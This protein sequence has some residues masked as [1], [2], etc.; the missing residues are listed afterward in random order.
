MARTPIQDPIKALWKAWLARKSPAFRVAAK[1]LALMTIYYLV[2]LSPFFDHNTIKEWL[3]ANARLASFV[4]NLMGEQSHVIENLVAPEHTFG[5]TVGKACAALNLVWFYCAAV[6]AFPSKWRR[7]IP[8]LLVGVPIILAL[9]LI[10]IM[11][12]YLI[13]V[14][15]PRAFDWVHEELW[16]IVLV[17]AILFLTLAWIGWAQN[18]DGE[19]TD[20]A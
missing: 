1:F 14:H 4:L 11:S 13:G 15:F 9:N 12:L 3:D 17:V 5:V 8:G 2:I 19:N 16:A 6:L 7:K 18:D 20:V 10:R